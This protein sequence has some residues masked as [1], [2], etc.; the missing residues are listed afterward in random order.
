MLVIYHQPSLATINAYRTIY[1][2][3][4]NAFE[5]LGHTFITLTAD[6]NLASVLQQHK[7]DL[8]MTS[9]H[10]YWRKSLDLKLL[11]SY[12]E[13]GLKVLVKV[14]FWQYPST[15]RSITEP[16][17][18]KDNAEVVRL[19]K[20]GMLG[21]C[22]HHVVAPGDWR[23]EGFK[24]TT[25]YDCLTIP[26]AADKIALKPRFRKKFSS[27]L[28]FLGTCSPTKREAFASML[29]PLKK[30]YDLRLYGQDW[31][32]GDRALG[33]IQ[34]FGQYFNLP[35]LKTIRKPK[36]RLEEEAEIYASTKVSLNIHEAQQV[37]YGGDCNERAFKIP[38]CGGF[39][40]S[41][42]VRCLHDYFID[43]KEIIIAKDTA[44]WFAKISY[45]LSNPSE[46]AAIITAGQNKVAQHHTYHNRVHQIEALVEKL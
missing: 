6:D 5:D 46:R 32:T 17:S 1:Y 31:T 13:K 3:Y 37:K 15:K 45:Y 12:R 11:K 40:I 39:Q 7:A 23:M 34:R 42:N 16:D 30:Q 22:F 20:T 2:G 19:I 24:K 9:S 27:D 14:D 29:F 18:L 43:N 36:L 25:G 33:W 41:D 35:V 26:L 28:A 4:K 44:D 8:L 38:F 21:D 10:Y